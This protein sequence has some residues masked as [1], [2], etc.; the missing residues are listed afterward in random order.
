MD[1]HAAATLQRAAG[2]QTAEAERRRTGHRLQIDVGQEVGAGDLAALH[3]GVDPRLSREQIGAAAEQIGG[4]HLRHDRRRVERERRRGDRRIEIGAAADQR[5]ERM[6]EQV[7]LLLG[8]GLGLLGLGEQRLGLL[9]LE[10][11]GE[12]V[13][14]PRLDVAQRLLARRDEAVG[15]LDLPVR[16]GKP[17]IGFGDRGR[18][19]EPRRGC[20]EARRV[21]AGRRLPHQRALATEQVEIP[22]Q[23]GLHGRNRLMRSTVRAV[24]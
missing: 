16:A 20:V 6:D 19:S 15:D 13:L 24:G 3:R 8:A 9:E 14:D 10:L 2:E 17:D 12:L 4:Q 22:A 18:D 5:R 11:A 7:A 1:R 21:R 23:I